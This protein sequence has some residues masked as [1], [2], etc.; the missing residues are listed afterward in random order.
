MAPGGATIQV[1]PDSVV[2]RVSW[3]D[4][5]VVLAVDQ[6]AVEAHV[7][8]RAPGAT[9]EILTPNA[10]AVVVGTVFTVEIAAS[11]LFST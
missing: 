8:P 5:R 1:R 3:T 10:R 2:R 6:G 9:F 4:E 11:N 7:P